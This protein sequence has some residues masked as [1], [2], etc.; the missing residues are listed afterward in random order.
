MVVLIV[1][2]FGEGWIED[3]EFVVEVTSATDGSCIGSS[4]KPRAERNDHL[5]VESFGFTPSGIE[6][7]VSSMTWCAAFRK[8]VL[9]V[10]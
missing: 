3:G 4:S 1:F 6:S 2:S 10:L 5:R 7:L 8:K 9:S